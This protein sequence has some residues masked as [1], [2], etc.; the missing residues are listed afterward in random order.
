MSPKLSL[1]IP[2][3]NTGA[4]L[5]RCLDSILSQSYTDFELLLVDDGSTDNSSAICEEYAQKDTR[6]KVFHREN[7]GICAA[8]NTGLDHAQ[9]EWIYQ[10]D[11]DDELI[12]DGLQTLMNCISEDVDVVMG[13]YEQYDLDGNLIETERDHATLT[14]SRRDSLLVLFPEHS[15]YYSYLGYV[16]IRLFRNRIIQDHTLRFDTT[17]RFKE[18]ALFVT[19]YLCKSNG[20]TRFTTT[21]VYKYI[22]QKN[23]E[24]NS[25]WIAYN[26]KYVYSFDAVVKMHS[27][28]RQ[29]PELDKQLS[30]AAKHEVVRRVY[31]IKDHMLVHHVVD[32]KCLSKLKRRAIK[33]VGLP[34]YL[35][36]QYNR[37]KRR[38]KKYLKRLLKTT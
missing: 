2:I 17:V 29:L 7:G 11:S 1:I 3:Y 16:W 34:Y 5:P 6:I 20:K 33:E 19:E 14:L 21:P 25:L 4:Y 18:D 12:P 28:I 27:S 15:L 26:P 9:G 8:R 10:M 23:S 30:K 13:G 31:M 32:I 35:E 24:M 36:Y 37:N 22:A 38:A